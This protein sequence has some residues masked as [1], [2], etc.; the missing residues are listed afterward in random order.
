MSTVTA[1][2]V[3]RSVGAD[4]EA[5]GARR[6]RKVKFSEE[7]RLVL[8]GEVHPLHADGA[9]GICFPLL[10]PLHR[11]FPRPFLSTAGLLSLRARERRR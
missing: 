6:D 11:R 2:R 1:K 10:L 9:R 7:G 3:T 5:T 4:E 8:V